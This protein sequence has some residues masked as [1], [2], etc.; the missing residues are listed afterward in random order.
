M[1]GVRRM[2]GHDGLCVLFSHIKF[3]EMSQIELSAL[4]YNREFVDPNR[5]PDGIYAK[6]IPSLYEHGT[7]IESLVGWAKAMTDPSGDCWFDQEYF[8]NLRKCVMVSVI[9]SIPA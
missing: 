2:G 1:Q 8:D 7:T 6:K 5:L 9:V 4:M 3:K